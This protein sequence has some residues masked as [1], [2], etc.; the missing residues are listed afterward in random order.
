M[1]TAE[2]RR[3]REEA[4]HR[5][6][7]EFLERFKA[8]R[9]Q[10]AAAAIA[11][12]RD[13]AKLAHGTRM[14]A[15]GERWRAH[16]EA[17]AT[18]ALPGPLPDLDRLQVETI[19]R[20]ERPVLFVENDWLNKTDVTLEGEEAKELVG[21]LDAHRTI[22][23]P[24]MPLIGRIDVSYLPG[25][26]Y[27]GT[28]WLVA[29]DVVVTNRHV[30]SLIARNDGRSF[31]F[32]LGSGGKE[33][34][35]ALC[36]AHEYDDD[37]P[38][39]AHV[40]AV[41]SVLYIEPDAGPNDIAFLRIARRPEGISRPFIPIADA[42]AG[43]DTPVV[44]IGYPA[45]APKSIIPDQ[46]LMTRLYR[47]RYDV[48]RA[49]P[50]YTQPSTGGV[51]RH[52]CTT[53][54]GNSG[55][56]VL[57]LATG[58][59]VGLHFA[60]VY[61]EANFAVRA[62]VLR[63]YVNGT[64]WN[65]P[66]RVSTERGD[67]QASEAAGALRLRSIGHTAPLATTEMRSTVTITIPLSVSVSV[68]TPTTGGA[69][70]TDSG[71]AGHAQRDGAAQ[72]GDGS[73]SRVSLAAAEAAARDFW[74]QRPDGVIA[75]RVGFDDD[76]ERIGNV[77][78]IAASVPA[79]RL[80]EVRASGPARFQTLE[81]SYYPADA[82]EQVAEWPTLESV[83]SISYDDDART[84]PGFSFEP[85]TE[86]MKVLAHVGPEYSWD[87]LKSF[88]TAENDSDAFVSA[89]YEFNARH[90]ADAIEQQLDHG[91][92]LRLVL[93]NASFTEMK[94]PDAEFDRVERF[95]S[96][97]RFGE[98]FNRIV[99]PEGTAGLISDSYHIKVTVRGDTFWLSSGNW[100]AESSQPIV[101]QKQRD[102]AANK[103]LPGNREWHVVVTN[104]TLA[105]RFRNH[106]EQDLE[107]SKE[108]GGGPV[109]KSK[110]AENVFV[111]VPIEEAV[112]L[113][114]RAPGR[115]VQPHTFDGQCTVQPLLTPDREG[116]VYSGAVLD[117][118]KSARHSLLFQ[119]PYIGMPSN[120]RQNRG[121]IDEL[122]KALTQKL[123]TLDDARV[124]L[125]VGGS[126]FSAP[127]HAAWYF[128]SKGVDIG[129]RLRQL[130]D[131]HTKGMVVDGQRVLVGSHNWSK[132]GVTL[133]RDAS[134]LFHSPDIAA[135]FAEAFEI[136]WQ[137]A[138][139]IRPKRFVKSEG[140]MLEAVGSAPPPGYRRVR[141]SELVKEDE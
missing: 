40:F 101:T 42:D 3:Q 137:R 11:R 136:D 122:I 103:D 7:L 85:V 72:S 8:R 22:I 38:D 35:V 24:L 33:L 44:V 17:V 84:G 59:A 118:I 66:V 25:L 39:D 51:T 15:L 20:R 86:A 91:A 28:G 99:A 104:A 60:G 131:T 46:S 50:G 5:Q 53:L 88:L 141:L 61:Q 34:E 70:T 89:M 83:D 4:R 100:K 36:T 126:K 128:K 92:S 109:P 12:A 19:V 135:Y 115:V 49:A 138:N 117:L 96:W 13:E 97:E 87:T 112:L 127:M 31:R 45:R 119:I 41:K 130:A 68:G 2:E 47:D 48:K 69:V 10:A 56:V 121:Y 55:S 23:S 54:G 107:R 14:A 74:D 29:P 43:P 110:E 26:D 133:N 18:E 90:I 125:R 113:E 134:L 76:G 65:A 67:G 1:D 58:A 71:A 93:D 123:K 37:A 9:P 116:A 94:D 108:L 106:I 129:A 132:P 120:P 139:Q 82:A 78:I 52:D 140:V 111:D 63:E 21:A 114:R 73:S 27:V 16:D 57:D 62:S 80:A 77:P 102:D 6:N 79:D 32:N 75:V 81:V 64:R 105:K 95:K 98:K 30:A 124:I